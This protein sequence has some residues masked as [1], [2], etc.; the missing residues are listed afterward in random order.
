VASLLCLVGGVDN[1]LNLSSK[2][3]LSGQQNFKTFE[4]RFETETVSAKSFLFKLLNTAM[5]SYNMTLVD[6]KLVVQ[7]HISKDSK[8]FYFDVHESYLKDF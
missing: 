4:I 8:S 1:N 6:D 7:V 5:N 3:M 2:S